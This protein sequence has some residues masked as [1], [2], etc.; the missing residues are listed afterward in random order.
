MVAT[1]RAIQLVSSPA[2]AG[3]DNLRRQR[4]S[5]SSVASS[6]G[7][8]NPPSLMILFSIHGMHRLG[9]GCH[10]ACGGSKTPCSTDR[11]RSY[12]ALERPLLPPSPAHAGPLGIWSRLKL[13]S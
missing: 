4:A 5:R 10:K 3:Q 12:D 7:D 13:E 11:K 1:W 9:G 6:A 8:P 2:I